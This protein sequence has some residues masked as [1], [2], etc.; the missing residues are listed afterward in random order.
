MQSHSGLLKDRITGLITVGIAIICVSAL[1][2]IKGFPVWLSPPPLEISVRFSDASGIQ[3]GDDVRI[4]GVLIG[5][6]TAMKLENDVAVVDLVITKNV[7]L[8][9][10]SRFAIRDTNVLGGK[11]LDVVLGKG[12]YTQKRIF[13]GDDPF[14]SLEILSEIFFPKEEDEGK[15]GL[16]D[17]F[18]D[19]ERSIEAERGILTDL[20]DTEGSLS[21]D[22]E[23]I[24]GAFSKTKKNILSLF[25]ADDAFKDDIEGLKD[26]FSDS[27]GEDTAAGVL[28]S[29]FSNDGSEADKH[30]GEIKNAYE[31]MGKKLDAGGGSLGVFDEESA[32]WAKF[33]EIGEG[34]KA[35]E[36]GLFY[37]L[38]EDDEAK[39][40]MEDIS[41]SY[42]AFKGDEEA[43]EN[44]LF[45]SLIS[46]AV[47]GDDPTAS[48][49]FDK[50]L[51]FLTGSNEDLRERSPFLKFMSILKTFGVYEGLKD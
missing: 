34:F 24:Q 43:S 12:M 23:D 18:E 2:C 8:R 45:S 4:R 25:F 47:E 28:L 20:F 36:K 51:S 22:F 48:N 40:V 3:E 1:I 41:T 27:G 5:Q 11:Y 7:A 15:P 35:Y 17:N 44:G 32:L 14:S 10:D 50:F 37:Y 42:S 49:A 46:D 29:I 31:D 6:V 19:I 38:F 16:I 26:S 13:K 9:E 39:A 30:F 33:R 21:R